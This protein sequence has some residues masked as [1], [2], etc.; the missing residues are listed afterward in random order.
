MN[1]STVAKYLLIVSL[2]I[3]IVLSSA[4]WI[5]NNQLNEI[6]NQNNKLE[7]QIS[8]LVNQVEEF[9][10]QNSQLQDQNSQLRD[11]LKVNDKS[12]WI[13]NLSLNGY[14]SYVSLDWNTIFTVGIQSNS[15][16]PLD[17]LYLTFNVVS[18]YTVDREV[19]IYEPYYAVLGMG[20]QYDFGVLNYGKT[21]E[22]KG[23]IRNFLDDRAKLRGSSFVVNLK[24]AGIAIDEKTIQL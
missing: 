22:V 9:E 23:I 11:L 5:L 16:L 24:L 14:I 19:W 6:Q 13:S 12:V 7:T 4:V 15:S 21:V 1:K 20:D 17:G 18:N 3:I 8:D 10:N 2:V